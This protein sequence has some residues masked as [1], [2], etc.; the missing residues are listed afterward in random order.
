MCEQSDVARAPG[1]LFQIGAIKK[2][3]GILKKFWPNFDV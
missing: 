1:E 3:L 2:R